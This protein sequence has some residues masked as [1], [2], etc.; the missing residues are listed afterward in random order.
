[1]IR[2]AVVNRSTVIANAAVAAFVPALQTQISRDFAPSWFDAA[3]RFT[4]KPDPEEWQLAILDD[5]DQ[6]GALGYHDVTASFQPLGKV[7]AKTVK[8]YGDNW[9]VTASHEAL[10]MLGDPRINLLAQVEDGPHSAT[11]YAYENCD[12]CEDDHFAYAIDGHMVSDFVLPAWFEPG[13]NAGPFDFQRRITKP[14]QLLKGGYIGA[15][16]S[17]RG[18]WTME[19]AERDNAKAIGQPGSRRERRARKW[20]TGEVVP[21]TAA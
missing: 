8:Q 20:E 2:I 16:E 12:A 7:F 17:S 11:F 1:M 3:L 13:N 14:L 19:T 9:E 18:H 4:D 15:F 21:S 6:A 10:E 5:S